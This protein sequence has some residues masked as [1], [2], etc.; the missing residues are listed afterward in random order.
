MGSFFMSKTLAKELKNI[1]DKIDLYDDEYYNNDTKVVTDEEY[2][3]LK[4]PTQR[5]TERVPA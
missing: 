3:G 4:R 5:H 1:L 2:D